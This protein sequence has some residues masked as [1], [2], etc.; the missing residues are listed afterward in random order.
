[1][2][3]L[4][5]GFGLPIIEAMACGV[6]VVTSNT[7]SLPEVAGGAAILVNPY[8][9]SAIADAISFALKDNYGRKEM[10][11]KGLKNA[12]RFSWKESAQKV[13]ET[14]ENVCQSK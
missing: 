7:S 12:K 6:P 2:P 4:Y 13:L 1:M 10:I 11:E 8:D 14:F 3:S 9:I 5:E